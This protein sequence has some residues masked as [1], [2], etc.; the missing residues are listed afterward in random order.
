VNQSAL[1]EPFNLGANSI[2]TGGGVGYS[3]RLSG[4][5]SFT[6]FAGYST[7]KPTASGEAAG[8]VRTH[9]YNAS[10]S[11][12]HTFSPKTNGSVGVS[13]YSF[14]TANLSGHQSTLSL[15]ATISH[16]F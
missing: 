8:S 6:A 4:L 9:N 2:Q 12:N 11:L 16:T 5:T 15:Y 14:G 3:H 7:A 10:A 1:P 13:Y